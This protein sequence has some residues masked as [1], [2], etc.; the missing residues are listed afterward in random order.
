MKSA[1]KLTLSTI[2]GCLA[3]STF[4]QV[5][6]L[7][8]AFD[9]GGR[10]MG[11]G[12]AFYA[13]GADT[14]SSY[15]NP[16][17]LGYVNESTAGLVYRN[18]PTSRTIMRTS[19][20]DPQLDSTGRRGSN[21]ITHL[22]V[23]VPRGAGTFG[24][25]YTVGGYIDDLRVGN[26]LPTGNLTVRNY[27]ETVKARADFFTF[28]FGRTNQAQN[29]SYGVGVQVVRQQVTNRQ[30]GQLFDA[31]NN[32]VGVFDADSSE[33]GTGFGLLVGMQYIPP[34][35]PNVSVGASFRTAMSLSGN[36][37]TSVLYDRIPAR[38]LAGIAARQDG[39]RTGNDFLVYGAQVQHFFGGR[40][41]ELFDRRDQTVLG[42]GVEYHY[43]LGAAMI[44]IR[45]GYN[46]VPSGG[47]DYASRNAFT[48]GV[49][50]RPG[51]ARY[52][53]DFNFA[54]PERGGYDMSVGINYRFGS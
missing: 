35:R 21:A 36:P 25:S 28:A 54:A 9:V 18:L 13:T 41:S 1:G 14:I 50:Y 16:A 5:P 51:G 30:V 10:A 19:F 52:A 11:A 3:A 6:D 20:D 22:G 43:A 45:L 34:N 40:R 17:G 31:E 42:F 12:G 24:I 32:Q 46:I 4:G 48:F 37:D 38:F 8:T 15:Y 7:L 39:L 47:D 29:L 49:G 33:S 2:G 23:A 27:Q 26:N 53:I 44:P